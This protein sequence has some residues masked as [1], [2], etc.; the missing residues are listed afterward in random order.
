MCGYTLVLLRK[1]SYHAKHADHHHPHNINNSCR[2]G[3]PIRSDLQYLGAIH[4]VILLEKEDG[5]ASMMTPNGKGLQTTSSTKWFELP[6]YQTTCPLSAVLAA[7]RS[8]RD[9]RCN[10][11]VLSSNMTFASVS[12]ENCENSEKDTHVR[13][14]I[15]VTVLLTP[16][17]YVPF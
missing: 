8:A 6:S 10:C 4:F 9:L 14:C 7:S 13:F 17:F 1:A 16:K 12:C 11:D 5:P 2:Q 15:L 3:F